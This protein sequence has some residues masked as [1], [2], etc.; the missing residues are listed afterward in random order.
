MKMSMLQLLQ[1]FKYWKSNL[2]KKN[3]KPVANWL[4]SVV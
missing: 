4:N 3:M 1:I 2:S